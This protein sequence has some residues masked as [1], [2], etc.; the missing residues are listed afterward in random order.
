MRYDP[1]SKFVYVGYGE[2]SLGIIN[3]TNYNIVG[4]IPLNG[5]PES[6]QIEYEKQYH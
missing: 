5:H 6:F 4:F 1:N 2:G 3:A